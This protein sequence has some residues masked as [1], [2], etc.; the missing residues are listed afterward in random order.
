[1]VLSKYLGLD[2]QG[3]NWFLDAEQGFLVIG[4]VVVWGAIP[5][6]AITHYAALTQ[7]P[8]ELEESVMAHLLGPL[9]PDPRALAKVAKTH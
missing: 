9:L 8:K 6:V 1:M 5:S 4:A 3:H 7:V 2:F